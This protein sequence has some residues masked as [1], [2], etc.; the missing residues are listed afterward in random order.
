MYFEIYADDVKLYKALKT[1][2][3]NYAVQQSELNKIFEWASKWQ[4]PISSKKC[5][6][7]LVRNNDAVLTRSENVV[8]VVESTRDFDVIVDSNLSF[9]PHIKKIVCR[10]IFKMN[11]IY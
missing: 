1:D 7:M 9:S 2:N 4:I 3:E 10:A 5:S 8:S 11:L 6:A